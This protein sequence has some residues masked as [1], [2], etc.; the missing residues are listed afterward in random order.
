MSKSNPED[1]PILWLAVSGNRDRRFLME[2]VR[3]NLKDR[4]TTVPGVA[5]VTFGGYID[6]NLRVWLDTEKR[7][8]GNWRRKM[9]SRHHRPARGSPRGPYRSAPSGIERAGHGRGRDR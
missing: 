2:Y 5:E 4:F 9:F 1:Q 6:P 3:D 7:G 8:K